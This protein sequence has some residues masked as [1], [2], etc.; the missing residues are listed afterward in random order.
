MVPFACAL[1]YLEIYY[2][3][4]ILEKKKSAGCPRHKP[5]ACGLEVVVLVRATDKPDY[6][7]QEKSVEGH[8][9]FISVR[10]VSREISPGLSLLIGIRHLGASVV[11][12][13]KLIPL[14]NSQ[15]Y[16]SES[17]K[18]PHSRK[19]HQSWN[20]PISHLISQNQLR[21]QAVWFS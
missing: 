13:S 2:Q 3:S 18:K 6:Q 1:F 5:V 16:E 7:I 14:Q 17:L 9:D 11:A 4:L 12:S 10:N 20:S 15:H 21:R 19:D 8:E